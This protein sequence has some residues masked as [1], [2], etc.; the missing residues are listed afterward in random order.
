MLSLGALYMYKIDGERLVPFLWYARFQDPTRSGT[1]NGMDQYIGGLFGTSLLPYPRSMRGKTAIAY[2]VRQYPTHK[3]YLL[4]VGEEISVGPEWE[5]LLSTSGFRVDWHR[6]DNEW[7]LYLGYEGE[8][9]DYLGEWDQQRVWMIGR[10]I[11]GYTGVR[12]RLSGIV[13]GSLE[14]GMQMESMQFTNRQSEDL[15]KYDTKYSPWAKL[16]L[17]TWLDK[18]KGEAE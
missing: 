10:A 3:H 1:L 15:L 4:Y 17:E 18:G 7:R 5:I 2:R 12:M 6:L 9:R 14:I 11:T 13:Y 16:A 8:G